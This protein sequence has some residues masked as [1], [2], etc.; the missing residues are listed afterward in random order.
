MKKWIK[1]LLVAGVVVS[2]GLSIPNVIT[3]HKT[4]TSSQTVELAVDYKQVYSNA[5][6]GD[7]KFENQIL[8]TLKR[9]GVNSIGFTENSL[10]ELESRELVHVMTGSELEKNIWSQNYN[11]PI[12]KQ[13]TYVMVPEGTQQK[14]IINTI[15][16]SKIG[17]TKEFKIKDTDILQ[18]NERKNNIYKLPLLYLESD[19]SKLHKLYTV[20]PRVSN[21]WEDRFPLINNQLEKWNKKDKLSSVV[22]LGSEAEGYSED[23][24]GKST[25]DIRNLWSKT[26]VGIVESFSSADRQKGV[27]EYAVK[28]NYNIVR[29]H[30]LPKEKLEKMSPIEMKRLIAKATKERNIRMIYLNPFY[31]KNEESQK[32]YTNRLK[33]SV[34]NIHDTVENSG[35]KIGQAKPFVQHESLLLSKIGIIAALLGTVYLFCLSL[36]TAFKKMEN[37]ALNTLFPMAIA[38]G[39]AAILF[40]YLAG[41]NLTIIK[42]ASLAL[43]ILLPVWAALHIYFMLDRK[44]EDKLHIAKDILG[45]IALLY[46]IGLS[47]LISMNHGIEHV[48]Y[49]ETFKGVSLTLSVPPLIVLVFLLIRHGRNISIKSILTHK[50]R[51]IDI[52]LLAF[53]GA[54]FVFYESRSGNGGTLLPFETVLRGYL[55]DRFPWRPRTKEIFFAFPLLIIMIGM[56]KQTKWTRAILP[57]VTVGFASVFNTFTHFHTPMVA[58]IGRSAISISSGML[59]GLFALI[60]IRFI[61]KIMRIDFKKE[62][63]QIKENHLNKK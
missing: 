56:W 40:G 6:S 22:F 20:V 16:K 43:S 37:P 3:K 63:T 34:Q 32:E 46:I 8:K 12:Q 48:T 50:I 49:I 5:Q 58:S 35:F 21:N 17:K 4:E 24:E 42:I 57:F 29:V 11:L 51:I 61:L 1:H 60:Y 10:S 38:S 18:I 44:E 2:F 19:Y 45:P 23:D 13:Y 41:T 25:V 9:S 28:T 47:Y 27:R 30:S 52:L 54:F 59:F 53:V 36:Y 7:D 33:D 62:V 55:E 15:K 26:G 39:T 31:L 14:E